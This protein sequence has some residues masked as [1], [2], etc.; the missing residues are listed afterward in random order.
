MSLLRKVHVIAE[1]AR[2]SLGFDCVIQARK[3][4]ARLA[5]R[6]LAREP[7]RSLSRARKGTE[8]TTN[9]AESVMAPNLAGVGNSSPFYRSASI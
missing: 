4:V 5:K 1:S 2:T 8:G 9:L 6:G 3:V 7:G